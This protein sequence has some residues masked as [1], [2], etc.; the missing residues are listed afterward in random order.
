V[1]INGELDLFSHTIN[2]LLGLLALLLPL[3]KNQRAYIQKARYYGA[4]VV[5]VLLAYAWMYFE[6]K[7]QWWEHVWGV[8]FSTHTAVHVAILS[9]LWQIGRR[10]RVAAVLIGVAY[11]LLM[12]YRHFHAPSDIALTTAAML[13]EVI[14]VWWLARPRRSSAQGSAAARSPSAE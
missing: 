8:T 10:W 5:V 9:C 13:P 6:R 12:V 7:Y 1:T 14:L 3:S 11:A 2:P 4:L